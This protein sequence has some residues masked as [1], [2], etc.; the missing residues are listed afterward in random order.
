MHPMGTLSWCFPLRSD[1]LQTSDPRM[2]LPLLL[3]VHGE[4][5]GD[6]GMYLVLH[7]SIL[8]QT[9]HSV[10]QILDSRYLTNPLDILRRKGTIRA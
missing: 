10:N 5:R 4:D 6:H 7:S 1:R 2:T 9:T 8:P 3:I